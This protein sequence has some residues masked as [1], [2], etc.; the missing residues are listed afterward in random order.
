MRPDCLAWGY[1]AW[2]TPDLDNRCAVAH[3]PP[4]R[5]YDALPIL[6]TEVKTQ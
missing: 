1:A 5:Y 3:M 4:L 2:L 6:T